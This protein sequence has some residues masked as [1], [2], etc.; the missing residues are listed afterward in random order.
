VQQIS[1]DAVGG[2]YANQRS[3]RQTLED[4]LLSILDEP[5]VVKTFAKHV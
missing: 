4:D 3:A 5:S 1:V 2:V